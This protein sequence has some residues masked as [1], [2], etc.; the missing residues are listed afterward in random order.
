[1]KKLFIYI[2]TLVVICL[3]SFSNIKVNAAYNYT[4]DME[5]IA[6]AE[7]LV[8]IKSVD[9]SNLVDASGNLISTEY[10]FGSLYDIADDEENIYLCDG[11]NNVIVVLDQNY[12]Y[13]TRF[14]QEGTTLNNPQG[15][16]VTDELIYVCDFGNNRVAIFN[17][18][19]ELVQ[20]VLT[21]TD[22]VFE[23]YEFRPKKITVS[24]TGRMYVVAEG[25]NEGILDFNS[26]GT[27]SRF[28]GMN[29]A[30]LS[31]WDAFWQLFTSEEQR[32][33]QGYN[34]GASLLNLCI[35]EEE[36][37]YTVS[38]PNVGQDFIKRLNYKA[39]DVL[40]RNGY[41]P[42]DG[43]VVDKNMP[44]DSRVPIDSSTFVDIDVNSDGT[45]IALDKTRGRIFAYDFEGNLLYE[46]GSLSTTID[47]VSSNQNKLFQ[48]PEGL[49][50][51]KDKI[52][53][54]DSKNK[55]LIIFEFTDF[56]KL[57]NEATHLYKNNEYEAAAEIWEK[58]LELNSNYLLA[59]AGIGKAQFR[60]GNYEE[61]LKNLKLGNDT[62]NYSQAYKQ[63]RYEKLSVVAPYILGI[64]LAGCVALLVRSF[65]K[66]ANSAEKEGE[67]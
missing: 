42:N 37:V 17:K 15:L 10:S 50:Y 56:G 54:V 44:L 52:L 33:S 7:S 20:E 28:Y 24:R 4:P 36:Y 3:I 23:G 14:P 43:D 59:Y 12:N 19:Y 2:S 40:N 64:V 60:Q 16:Y 46:A 13:I 61:A 47:G 5:E 30:T 53:T 65:V 67:I 49:C 9:S 51:Y 21:P 55:N 38:S 32:K 11:S 25:V 39:S 41:V 45:Y 58:V 66:N 34:F 63:Y 27:F 29:Q 57:V 62:Y 22:K 26:D 18:N 1:M 35:D 8:P 6:S 31:A 48:L